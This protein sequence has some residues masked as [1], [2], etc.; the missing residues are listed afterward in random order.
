MLGV[1]GEAE[2]SEKAKSEVPAAEDE[3][4]DEEELEDFNEPIE[5]PEL[6]PEQPPFR[7]HKKFLHYAFDESDY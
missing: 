3:E 5:I 6:E 1:E 7:R 4:E 2:E